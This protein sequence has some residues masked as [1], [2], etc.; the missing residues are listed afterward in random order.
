MVT[1][2]FEEGK[3]DEVNSDKSMNNVHYDYIT[4]SFIMETLL[5]FADN[6]EPS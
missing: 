4:S 6:R 5:K 3:I 1:E 2:S